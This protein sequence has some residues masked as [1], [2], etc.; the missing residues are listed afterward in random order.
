MMEYMFFDHGLMKRFMEA[1]RQEGIE[2][3]IQDDEL[4]LIAAIP[5]DIPDETVERLED[6]YDQLMDEQS[7][8]VDQSDG[9]LVKHVAGFQLDLPDGRSRMVKLDP[10]V[11]NRLLGEFTLEE[12]QQLFATVV[13]AVENP[14]T[15]PICKT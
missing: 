8:L 6:L 7:Q 14:L 2:C 15:V 4:G 1:A 10:D 9:G 12:I 11:A 5:E 13:D 3:R